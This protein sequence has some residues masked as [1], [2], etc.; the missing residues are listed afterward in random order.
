M[1]RASNA[2]SL[3]GKSPF[4]TLINILL[5]IT[6]CVGLYYL[7]NW[8]YNSKSAKE[9]VVILSGNP[10]MTKDGATTKA[11]VTTEITGLGGT[12]GYM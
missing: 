9:S 5:F 12:S 6:V 7:Y 4:S 1:N 2:N 11:V 8:L 10:D 3:A